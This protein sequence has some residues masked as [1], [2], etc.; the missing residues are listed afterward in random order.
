MT[1]HRYGPADEVRVRSDERPGHHRIP[2]YC[3]GAVGNVVAVIGTQPLPDD[4]VAHRPQPRTQP[5]YT[6]RLEA[7]DLF[8]A[9]DHT[10][11]VDLW[12]DYLEAVA[13]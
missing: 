2:G 1:G 11:L 5:V 3:R 8:G 10:V 4:V 9:G 13:R 7:A 6:V 12:E